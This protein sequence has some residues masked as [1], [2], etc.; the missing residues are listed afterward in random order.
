MGEGGFI[1]I[2][3]VVEI[4][5]PI[6]ILNLYSDS[7]QPYLATPRLLVVADEGAN[8]TIIE[9]HIGVSDDTYMTIPVSEVKV[10]EKAHIHHVRI[11]RDSLK[12]IHVSRPAT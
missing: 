10:H 4:P 1:Y 11:Q 8:A 6:Q 7:D 5:A 2:P 3:E 9:D 12:A